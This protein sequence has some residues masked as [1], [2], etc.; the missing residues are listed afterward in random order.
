M[1]STLSVVP[2]RIS[3]GH[4]TTNVW[5]LWVRVGN[6][7][8]MFSCRK[9]A[10]LWAKFPANQNRSIRVIFDQPD[11]LES[12]LA[13]KIIQLLYLRGHHSNSRWPNRL[14]SSKE[15]VL[16]KTMM[17]FFLG[18]QSFCTSCTLFAHWKFV[19]IGWFWW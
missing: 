11:H 8:G 14:V 6:V 3:H 13:L 1:N 16:Y 5:W 10:H 9:R 19:C 12:S 15:I 18:S 17:N 4:R 2:S 7:S